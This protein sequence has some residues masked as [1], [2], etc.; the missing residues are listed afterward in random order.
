MTL[1]DATARATT[2]AEGAQRFAGQAQTANPPV[3]DSGAPTCS[4]EAA[5]GLL[6]PVNV[7]TPRGSLVLWLP[8]VPMKTTHHAKRIV[9]MK[10]FS[11][12]ADKPE[13][14]AAKATLDS[15]L[16]PHQ[17]PT[18][19]TGPVCLSLVFTWPWLASDSKRL[20]AASPGGQVWHLKRP[21]CSNLA[22]TLEDR[23]V[24]LRFIEDDN[25]VVRLVVEKY[26]GD[27][28]G[29]G[30]GITPLWAQETP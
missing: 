19:V 25:A 16:L 6:S 12:L 17:P 3:C 23:L 7:L 2:Q 26:R 30:I 11:R 1:F 29:I 14:V 13:L 24:V 10:G 21:D 4:L 27:R 20:K 9:R 18:P 15:L 28:P 8:C 5:R 22:K